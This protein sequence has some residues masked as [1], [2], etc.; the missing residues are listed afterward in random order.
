MSTKAKIEVIKTLI[1]NHGFATSGSSF[2]KE[3]GYT[4]KTQMYR[5]INGNATIG[6]NSIENIWSKICDQYN[7][8]DEDVILYANVLSTAK[9]LWKEVQTKADE[10]GTDPMELAQSTLDGLLLIDETRMRKV[11]N[12]ADWETLLDFSHQ[13]PMQY[14]QLIVLFYVRYND[15][16]KVEKGKTSIESLQLLEQLFN[17]LHTLQPANQYLCDI[18]TA[19]RSELKQQHSLGNLWTNILRPTQMVQSFTDP[20]FLRNAISLLRLLPI[21]YDSLW[22][23][24]DTVP[25]LRGNAYIFFEVRPDGATGGRYDCIEIDAS[26]LDTELEIKQFFMIGLEK[27]EEGESYALAFLQFFDSKGQKQCTNYIYQYDEEHHNLTFE[28]VTSDN[29]YHDS[30]QLPKELHFIDPLHPTRKDEDA[31]REWYKDFI[32][33]NDDEITTRM[34][35]AEK[36][37]PEPDYDITD[38]AISRRYLTVT[39]VKDDVEVNY[40]MPIDQDPCIRHID[41][42]ADVIMMRHHDNDELYLEWI[43]PHFSVPFEAFEKV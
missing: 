5:I 26:T 38:V 9:D 1:D 42:R 23:T 22:I 18:A 29:P 34:L 4:G 36:M 14:A 37:T 2:A 10:T 25:Q 28:P 21:P 31:W 8:S 12:L 11:L 39:I 13:H 19:Y 41:P 33:K 24:H 3:I 40:R 6:N 43:S 35:A 16:K 30:F 20:N 15:M 27:P 17:H 7:L 32:E